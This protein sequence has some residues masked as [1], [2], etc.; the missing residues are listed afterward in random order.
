MLGVRNWSQGLGI[1]LTGLL[2]WQLSV[3]A[4]AQAGFVY[5]EGQWSRLGSGSGS[6]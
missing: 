4:I 1:V 6:E 5:D 3:I 2:T